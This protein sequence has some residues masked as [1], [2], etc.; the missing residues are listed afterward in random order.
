MALRPTHSGGESW[1]KLQSADAVERSVCQQL[2]SVSSDSRYNHRR[3]NRGP[4][5][6]D[7]STAPLDR[8]RRAGRRVGRDDLA[9]LPEQE[10]PP[11]T[12]RHSVDTVDRTRGELQDELQPNSDRL[13]ELSNLSLGFGT[14]RTGLRRC[15]ERHDRYV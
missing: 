8:R 6:A 12:A 14:E 9:N 10:Q 11:R 15:V 5:Y 3:G 7:G 2:D 4:V 13:R 1:A